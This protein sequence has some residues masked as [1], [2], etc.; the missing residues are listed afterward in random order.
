MKVMEQIRV[1]VVLILGMMAL[2]L[3]T[4]GIGKIY[5]ELVGQSRGAQT[6]QR[7]TNPDNNTVLVL[8]EVT[9]W[10]CQVGVFQNESNA[11]MSKE[12]IKMLGFKAEVISSNPWVVG[13]GLG[14]STSELK[15]LRTLLAEKGIYTVPKQITLPERSFRVAGKGAQLTVEMLTNVNIILKGGMMAEA[16][17]KEHQLWNAQADN[18]PPKDLEELHQYYNLL[19]TK[20]T[21]E[22]QKALGLSLFYESQRVINLLSGK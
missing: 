16:L 4:W 19:R 22:E 2:G 17:A 13:I 20:T 9:F 8:P 12:Q 11:Q 6:S 18:H 15:G 3:L 21:P 14:H 7:G 10:T 1:V 5:I